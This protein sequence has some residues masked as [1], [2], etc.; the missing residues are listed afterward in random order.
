MLSSSQIMENSKVTNHCR[1]HP[2]FLNYS[3]IDFLNKCIEQISDW[4]CL[5]LLQ[6][7]RQVKGPH[8]SYI[9]PPDRMFVSFCDNVS[10]CGR[11]AFPLCYFCLFLVISVVIFCLCGHIVFLLNNFVVLF[12]LFIIN[13]C[14]FVIS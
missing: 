9:G 7:G 5:S 12:C 3:P 2:R 4:L 10:S 8:S 6:L 1:K 11:F 14:V 13:Q